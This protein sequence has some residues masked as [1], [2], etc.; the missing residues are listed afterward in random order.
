MRL[1][2]SRYITIVGATTHTDGMAVT[3]HT[4]GA[5]ATTAT[6]TI[7]MDA[8]AITDR[9]FPASRIQNPREEPGALAAH[10]EMLRCGPP[11]RLIAE[12]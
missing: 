3:T 4:A 12:V 6:G 11:A 9:E 10:A 5:A 1:M 7:G 8:T 2:S